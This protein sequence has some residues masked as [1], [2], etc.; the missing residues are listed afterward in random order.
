MTTT[1]LIKLLQNVE[2]GGSGRSREIR[3]YTQTKRG[4]LKKAIFTE[5]DKL[6]IASTGD[7]VAGA[8]LSLVIKTL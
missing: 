7:G 1:E 2:K 4:L 3:I 8:E 5:S 6:E